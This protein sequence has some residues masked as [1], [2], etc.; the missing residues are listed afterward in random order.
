MTLVRSE[1][2]TQFRLASRFKPRGI[3]VCSKKIE[4]L[5]VAGPGES[6]EPGIYDWTL[7]CCAFFLIGRLL[8]HDPQRQPASSRVGEG[9]VEEWRIGNL[10]QRLF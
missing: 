6:K 1:Y 10:G 4:I 5:N 2:S 3:F 8:E 7:K 9:R